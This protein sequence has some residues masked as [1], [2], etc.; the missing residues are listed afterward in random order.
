MTIR[1][2]KDIINTFSGDAKWLSAFGTR[3]IIHDFFNT[4]PA[5][6]G[7]LQDSQYYGKQISSCFSVILL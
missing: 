1:T 2:N 3:R 5:I 4:M 6:C 7:L